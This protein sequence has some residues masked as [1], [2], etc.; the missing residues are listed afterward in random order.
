MKT[1]WIVAGGVLA[2]AA[3]CAPLLMAV[4]AGAGAGA[5]AAGLGAW[6]GMPWDAVLCGAAIVAAA[7]GI[8]LWW[9]GQRRAKTGDACDCTTTCGT[10]KC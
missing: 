7:V 10:G 9:Y 3:C 4:S 2:C 5:A 1:R 8:G 6:A